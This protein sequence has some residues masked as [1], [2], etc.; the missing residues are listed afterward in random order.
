MVEKNRSQKL[1]RL[2]SVQRHIERMAENDLAETSRQRVEVNAAMDDVIVALGS[3]DPVHHAFSQN[4]AD[5][6]GRL[7]IKDQQ[8][9]GMQQV[10]EMRLARERAKG[11]R[12]EEGMKEALEAERR[13]ADDNAVYDVID[14]Q[15]ATPASSK[16]Q[17]P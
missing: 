17:N 11:D 16:L 7:S 8:L 3:M 4:Y 6:F 15:F 13:E 9:T 10:H 1:K 2:L 14:Q 12:F 5:R